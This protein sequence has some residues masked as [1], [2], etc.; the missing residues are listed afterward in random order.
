VASRLLRLGAPASRTALVIVATLLLA[1]IALTHVAPALGRSLFVVRGA[2]MD[3]AVPLGSLVI[4]QRV[5][6]ER[7]GEGTVVTARGTGSAVVTHRVVRRVGDGSDLR[8]ELK[9]DAN[10]APDPVLVPAA[11]VVGVVEAQVPLAGYVLA[12][13]RSPAGLVSWVALLLTLWLLGGLF[14]DLTARPRGALAGA[15][16]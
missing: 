8:F 7:I 1:L 12:M 6:A 15:W 4:V 16:T 2:S 5:E 13:L 11:D 14:D 10:A 3:P 9:G